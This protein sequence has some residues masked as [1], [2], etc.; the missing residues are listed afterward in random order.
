VVAASYN[1]LAAVLSDLGHMKQAKEY[2]ER[3]LAIRLQKLGPYHTLVAASHN[4]LAAVI[5]DP[6]DLKQAKEYHER[7][8]IILP[9]TFAP[10]HPH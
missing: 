6:G 7:A 10:D 3:A 8:L 4:N 9:K 1:K 5:S 2:H